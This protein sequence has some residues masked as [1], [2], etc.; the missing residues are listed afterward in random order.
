MALVL[1]VPAK[2]VNPDGNVNLFDQLCDNVTLKGGSSMLN[3]HIS[4][5]KL[6]C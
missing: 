2:S 3:W 1:S 5:Q 4:S 6:H